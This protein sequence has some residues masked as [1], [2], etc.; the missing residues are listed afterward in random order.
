M[1]HIATNPFN[2]NTMC[3]YFNTNPFYGHLFS[4]IKTR[5]NLW[6]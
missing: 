6:R 5:E 2:N 4:I 3:A 1:K